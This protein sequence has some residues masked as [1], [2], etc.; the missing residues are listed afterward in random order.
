M[1]H[2]KQR[3]INIEKLL[4]GQK[5]L[6]VF[7]HKNA[8][9]NMKDT[10]INREIALFVEAGELI[11]EIG[12]IWK[13]WKKNNKVHI[14][15]VKSECSDVLHFLL[16]QGNDLGVDPNHDVV[17]TFADP[18]DQVNKFAKSVIESGKS[19]YAWWTCFAYYRGLL[20]LLGIEW[21]E[22]VDEYWAKHD[23]NIDRQ[24]NGY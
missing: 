19:H 21:D 7:F 12:H 1:K 18:V 20:E 4:K 11:N 8:E 13:Y 9:K 6:D 23:I 24:N 15:F 16:S 3:K 17:I 5:D 2:T 22:M 14:H 10:I